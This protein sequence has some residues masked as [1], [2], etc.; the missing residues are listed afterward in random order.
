MEI[1]SPAPF[2][3]VGFYSWVV[4]FFLI[5]KIILILGSFEDQ[6]SC[7]PFSKIEDAFRSTIP[8]FAKALQILTDLE[9][10]AREEQQVE[11][12]TRIPQ[13]H[14]ISA[15]PVLTCL[16]LYTQN[17]EDFGGVGDSSDVFDLL[18]GQAIASRLQL[19]DEN[20]TV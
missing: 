4:F 15:S 10:K 20:V 13:F 16:F 19:S 12:R 17:K 11:T 7:I 9:R 8:D 6:F 2:C 14:L 3:L 18:G 5:L 1:G